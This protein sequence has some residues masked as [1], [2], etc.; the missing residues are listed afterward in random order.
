MLSVGGTYQTAVTL[1][2][3]DCP[4]QGVE[5]HPTVVTHSP[6]ATSLSLSHAGSTYPG[7]VQADGRFTTT[8][9][10]QVIAGITY[11][12]GIS[13]RFTVTAIDAEVTVAAGRQPPCTF[14]ARWAGPK[15][16]SP[17]VIP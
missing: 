2:R 3:S 14:A 5:Q 15:I 1:L 4:G 13:G 11:V 6:G 8:D 16:G 17:N 7:T 12:V 9:V 10:T